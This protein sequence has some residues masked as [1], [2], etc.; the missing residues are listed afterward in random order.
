M[1]CVSVY[2]MC[3]AYCALCCVLSGVC[4]MGMHGVVGHMLYD[5]CCVMCGNC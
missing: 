1:T 3:I 4:V 5:V 2:V